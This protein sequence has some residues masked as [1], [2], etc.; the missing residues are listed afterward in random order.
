MPHITLLYPFVDRQRFGSAA[1][2]LARAC[3][4]VA[5][6]Q[7]TLARFSY[8][9]HRHGNYTVWLTPEPAQDLI[10]L[11]EKLWRAMPEYD[12]TRRHGQGFTPHLSVGQVRGRAKLETLLHELAVQWKP[13]E[14]TAGEISLIGRNEPPDDVFVVERTIAFGSRLLRPA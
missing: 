6:F 4:D 3:G 14:F 2:V 8:F 10:A 9:D 5:P 11:Q 7:L 1:A 13:L 12:D